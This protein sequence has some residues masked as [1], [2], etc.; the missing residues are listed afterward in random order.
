M[1]KKRSV[2]L[3]VSIFIVL[4]FVL[5]YANINGVTANKRKEIEFENKVIRYDRQIEDM[6][7]QHLLINGNIIENQNRIKAI[8][9]EKYFVYFGR[10]NCPY[11]QIFLPN[12]FEFLIDNKNLNIY[13]FDTNIESENNEEI[14]KKFNLE[15]VPSLFKV[16]KSKIEKYDE[17]NNSF[18]EFFSE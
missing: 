7:N 5:I 16:E 3:F 11:C 6:L 18:E 4:I 14:S 17:K 13:Y 2:Q 12:L 8:Q 9:P 15:Y 10:N 1:L